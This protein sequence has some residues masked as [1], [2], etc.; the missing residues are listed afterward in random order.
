MK[1]KKKVWNGPTGYNPILGFVESGKSILGL[2]RVSE[3]SLESL[4]PFLMDES[5]SAEDEE[6]TQLEKQTKKSSNKRK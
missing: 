3:A 6:E 1:N 5:E 4:R 2:E